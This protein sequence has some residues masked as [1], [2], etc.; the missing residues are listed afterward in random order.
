MSSEDEPVLFSAVTDV[1]ARIAL[2]VIN[3]GEF[4]EFCMSVRGDVFSEFDCCVLLDDP[5]V[6]MMRDNLTHWLDEARL[7]A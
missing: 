1:E 4:L 2:K 5:E 7:E 3:N 6:E